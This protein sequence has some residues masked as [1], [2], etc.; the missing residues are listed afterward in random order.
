[1][2]RADLPS[3]VF[4]PD[5]SLAHHLPALPSPAVRGYQHSQ[6]PPM[7]HPPAFGRLGICRTST[8]LDWPRDLVRIALHTRRTGHP[9]PAEANALRVLGSL[10]ASTPGPSLRRRPTGPRSCAPRSS[11]P[12]GRTCRTARSRLKC[13]RAAGAAGTGRLVVAVR[14]RMLSEWSLSVL[15]ICA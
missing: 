11:L 7:F 8:P 10:T 4:W 15:R 12:G 5:A 9:D 3:S 6:C 13:R 2:P 1:M 14:V